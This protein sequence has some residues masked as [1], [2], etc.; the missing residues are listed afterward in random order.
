MIIQPGHV[1]IQPERFAVN[2]PEHLELGRYY[3]LRGTVPAAKEDAEG[4]FVKDAFGKIE[5]REIPLPPQ[6]VR[7]DSKPFFADFAAM[8]NV[9]VKLYIDLGKDMQ[10]DPLFTILSLFAINVP[11]H[12]QHDHHLVK[13]SP[14]LYLALDILTNENR[15]TDYLEKVE[16]GA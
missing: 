14:E 11:E 1:T 16:P 5:M 7:I 8:G 3:W 10:A 2:R 6:I 13:V 15:K 4:R 12:G 9:R